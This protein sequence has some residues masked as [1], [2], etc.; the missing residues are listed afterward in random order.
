M[1]SRHISKC[2]LD[3]C[4]HHFRKHNSTVKANKAVFQNIPNGNTQKLHAS[5]SALAEKR[6]SGTSI[7][8]VGMSKTVST[9][10]LLQ[11]PPWNFTP[12]QP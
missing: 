1:H 7:Y 2:K 3:E 12:F 4:Y 8:V 10:N 5:Y 6:I 9:T 11:Y